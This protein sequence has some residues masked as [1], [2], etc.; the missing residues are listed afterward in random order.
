MMKER[1]M[2]TDTIWNE[3]AVSGRSV[4][5]SDALRYQLLD[6]ASDEGVRLEFRQRVTGG[7]VVYL[8]RA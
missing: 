8:R 5:G 7:T 1:E 3:L 6:E 4:V 2:N